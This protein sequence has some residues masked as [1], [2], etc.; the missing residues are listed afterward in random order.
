DVPDEEASA[1]GRR[2]GTDAGVTLCYRRARA[3]PEWPYNLYCMVHGRAREAVARE[4]ERLTARHGLGGYARQ[5]LFSTRC[6]SQRAA[7][8]G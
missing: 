8:Y 7:R 3:L 6:F 4:I 5:V 2:L 1:A